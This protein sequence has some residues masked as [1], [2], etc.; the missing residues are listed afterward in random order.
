ML[1]DMEASY[2]PPFGGVERDLHIG[3]HPKVKDLI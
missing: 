3:K 2:V 1:S